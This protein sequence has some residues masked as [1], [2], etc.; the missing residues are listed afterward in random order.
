M[1]SGRVPMTV[2]IR[3]M[4]RGARVTAAA[5]KDS[6]APMKVE[7]IITALPLRAALLVSVV[8]TVRNDARNIEVL[9]D[10]LAIHEPPITVIVVDSNS[11][12]E[13]RDIERTYE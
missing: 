9:F 12:D 4:G 13:T 7:I 3:L 2:T 6:P 10:S 8:T 11:E 5:I 1:I